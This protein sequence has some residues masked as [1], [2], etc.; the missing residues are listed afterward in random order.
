MSNELKVWLYRK[1]LEFKYRKYDDDIC[2]CGDMLT[3][4]GCNLPCRSQKEYTITSALKQL[5]KGAL[6]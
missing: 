4:I 6:K 1:W 2:C 3:N 5:E